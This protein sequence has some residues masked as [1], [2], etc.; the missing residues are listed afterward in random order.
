MSNP[1]RASSTHNPSRSP[2][3]GRRRRGA[4]LSS[5]PPRPAPK[6]AR[7]RRNSQSAQ[8]ITTV[9]VTAR[10]TGEDVGAG[11][12]AGVFTATMYSY[13]Y[14]YSSSTA[15]ARAIMCAS[16]ASAER[17]LDASKQGK[18]VRI[19][20]SRMALHGAQNRGEGARRVH[21]R[22]VQPGSGRT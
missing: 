4:R 15:S 16:S 22:E 14:E 2:V 18:N 11:E 17:T 20:T 6:R 12:G 5:D 7:A 21:A 13:E 10:T 9:S 1:R 3:A 19:S 8:S